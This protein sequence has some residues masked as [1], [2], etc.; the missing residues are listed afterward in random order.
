MEDTTIRKLAE[1]IIKDFKLTVRDRVDS[2]L[3]LD[4]ISYQNLGTDSH[5]YEKNKVK[6]DSKYLYKL[7]S[8]IDSTTGKQLIYTLDK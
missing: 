6:A 1:T 7:I 5:K 2:V 4:A 8:S 3:E